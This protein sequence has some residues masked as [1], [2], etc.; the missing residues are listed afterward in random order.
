LSCQNRHGPRNP[1]AGGYG[2]TRLGP[3]YVAG[4]FAFTNN[5]FNTDHFAFGDRITAKFNGQSIGGRV[6]SGYRHVAEERNFAA[7]NVGSCPKADVTARDYDVR[8]RG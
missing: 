5:W 6:E 8:F 3:I 2:K 4:A 7:A 1:Q